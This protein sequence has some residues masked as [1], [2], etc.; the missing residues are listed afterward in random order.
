MS[1]KSVLL[2]GC[3]A[4]AAQVSDSQVIHHH[5]DK[6]GSP[7]FLKRHELQGHQQQKT[8]RPP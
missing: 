6:V 4:V 3:V 8:K 2:E 1:S 5:Q 7:G